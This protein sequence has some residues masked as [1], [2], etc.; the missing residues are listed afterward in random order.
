MIDP[1]KL[2]RDLIEIKSSSNKTEIINYILTLFRGHEVHKIIE[3]GNPHIVVKIRSKKPLYFPVVFSMHVDTIEGD[4]F[5]NVKETE[6]N[7]IGLGSCDMKGS[8]AAVC[9]AVLNKIYDRDIYLLFSSDE[10]SLGKGSQALKKFVPKNSLVIVTEP[11]S[12]SLF[13][14]QN[15]CISY[16]VILKG[17]VGHAGFTDFETIKKNSAMYKAAII[18]KFLVEYGE[19]DKDLASQNIG[20]IE[21]GSSS[22]VI[23][24]KVIL[25]FEQRFKPEID[26]NEKKR[27]ILSKLKELGSESVQNNFFGEGFKNNEKKLEDNLI[28]VLSKYHIFKFNKTYRGWTE[29]SIFNKNAS[30]FILGPGEILNA[31]TIN[32]TIRKKDIFLFSE[33]YSE[34][35]NKLR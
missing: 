13:N 14:S 9:S 18:C 31:H 2:A 6:D 27:Y 11:S 29:A 8:I 34:I 1:L 33:V 26:L 10:E 17:I 15:S 5:T 12:Y 28:K 30:C 20:R 25:S 3:E 23:S 4:W 7:L 32:E 22:N 35:L 19:N 21:G 24:D 16:R